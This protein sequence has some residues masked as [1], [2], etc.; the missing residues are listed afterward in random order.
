MR[1]SSCGTENPVGTNFCEECGA[2]LARLC[3][4]CGH[5]LRPTAKFCGNCG[6]ALS[7]QSSVQSLASE[8]REPAPSPQT[9][10]SRLKDSRRDVAERRQLTVMFVDLVGS[11]VLSTQLDPE[12][13]HTVVQRYHQ[14]GEAVVQRYGGFVPQHLGDGLRLSHRACR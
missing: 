8:A 14:T 5:E 12:D 13:Y 4:S 2:R 10:D 7:P 11:T 3:P 6:A 1:C 9:L